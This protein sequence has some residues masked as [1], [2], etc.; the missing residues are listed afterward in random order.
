MYVI[1]CG[2]TKRK[3]NNN[4]RNF[5]KHH[6]FWGCPGI[7]RLPLR[8]ATAANVYRHAAWALY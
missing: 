8:D 1:D 4:T 3:R 7:P 5:F 2:T 6:I